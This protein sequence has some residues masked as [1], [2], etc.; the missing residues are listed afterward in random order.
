V[1]GT[2]AIES[3]TCRVTLKNDG[4]ETA[5]GVQVWVRPYRGTRTDDENVG[6]SPY[7]VLSDNDPLSLF[8]EWVPFPDLAPGQSSTQS[9]VFVARQ[10]MHPGPNSDPQIIF[11]TEKAAP[12]TQS[13][14]PAL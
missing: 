14:S 6:R 1:E 9:V 11:K 12:P 8:G 13:H 4:T 5:T 10:G 7:Q 3:F 2:P